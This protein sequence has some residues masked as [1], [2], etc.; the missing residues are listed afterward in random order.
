[1][2]G[3][4]LEMRSRF[5]T[6]QDQACPAA[7][8]TESVPGLEGQQRRASTVGSAIHL[9]VPRRGHVL[10]TVAELYGSAIREA[11]AVLSASIARAPHIGTGRALRVVRNSP[12]ASEGNRPDSEIAARLIVSVWVVGVAIKAIPTLASLS[13]AGSWFFGGETADPLTALASGHAIVKA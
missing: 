4:V 12:H 1:M 8:S 7:A 11:V 2:A 5:D 3:P 9:A 6:V 10:S 13:Q